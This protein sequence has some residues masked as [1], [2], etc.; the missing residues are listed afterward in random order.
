MNQTHFRM[1]L[2][3]LVCEI[4]NVKKQLCKNVKNFQVLLTVKESRIAI[5]RGV[6]GPG[7][8]DDDF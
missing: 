1:N 7:G 2:K 8:K 6:V 4:N 5:E 3:K